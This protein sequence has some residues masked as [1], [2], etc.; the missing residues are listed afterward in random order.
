M[1]RNIARQR[2]LDVLRA[3]P[4]G[5]RSDRLAD[6]AG[7]PRVQARIGELR[8]LGWRID[9]TYD[10]IG[11]A[12]YTIVGRGEAIAQPCAAYKVRI[13]EDGGRMYPEV[14]PYANSSLSGS[15]GEEDRYKIEIALRLALINHLGCEDDSEDDEMIPVEID[16]WLLEA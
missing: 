3:H 7:T 6:E 2:V 9:T 11:L 4:S 15:M 1:N 12:R 5:V 8:R 14:I 10:D 16:E 13:H